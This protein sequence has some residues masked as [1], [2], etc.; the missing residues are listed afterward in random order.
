MKQGS[1]NSRMGQTKVEP[2][3]RAMNPGAV[4][5]IGIALGTHVTEEGEVHGAAEKMHTGRGYHAP[6]VECGNHP[7][8]SQGKHR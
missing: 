6:K 1:G 5:Q 7:S 8:G 3:S 2:K 4:G